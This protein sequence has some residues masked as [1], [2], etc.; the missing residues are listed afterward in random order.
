VFDYLHHRVLLYFQN[1]VKVIRWNLFEE[2]CLELRVWFLWC[3]RLINCALST[4]DGITYVVLPLID[5]IRLALSSLA[6]LVGRVHSA[7]HF[8][9]I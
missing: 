1:F 6:C 9:T 5:F 3:L 7:V 8:L 4:D 2:T